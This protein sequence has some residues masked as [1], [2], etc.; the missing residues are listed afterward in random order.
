MRLALSNTFAKNFHISTLSNPVGLNSNK[1]KGF[2]NLFK[3]NLRTVIPCR[4]TLQKGQTCRVPSACRELQV[5]SGTAW[6]TVDGY[7]IILN[8]GE[9]VSVASDSDKDGA[10]VSALGNNPLTLQVVSFVG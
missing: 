4:F 9:K 8:S 3:R 1:F 5:V 6:I 7:D 10:V 2:T